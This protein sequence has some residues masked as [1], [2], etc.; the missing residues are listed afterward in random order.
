MKQIGRKIYYDKA[1]GEVIQTISERQGFVN[2]TTQ[3]QDF[4]VYNVLAER[5]YNTVG[6]IQ[7]AYGEMAEDFAMAESYRVDIVTG[8]L[9]FTY[10]DPNNPT[11]PSV[12]RPS[13][14]E[15]ISA[16]ENAML[17]NLGL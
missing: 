7:L 14:E 4:Q 1:T 9:V 10:R 11:E 12:E 16:L 17:V 2:E 3:E 13:Y 15:R 8:K 6:C 5:V